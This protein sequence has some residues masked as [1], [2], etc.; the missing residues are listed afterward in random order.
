MDERTLTTL[1]REIAAEDRAAWEQTNS[2]SVAASW[3]P[4][5]VQLFWYLL[6]KLTDGTAALVAS[7]LEQHACPHCRERV[8]LLEVGRAGVVWFR[9]VLKLFDPKIAYAESGESL[10]VQR[11]SP[12]GKLQSKLVEAHRQLVLEVRT[13]ETGRQW[14]L[15]G[16][17]LQSTERD[18]ELTGFLVLRPNENENGWYAAQVA[19]DG[20]KAARHL[21][22]QVR[23][24]IGFVDETQLTGKEQEMLIASVERSRDDARARSAWHSWAEDG[25]ARVPLEAAEVRQLYRVVGARLQE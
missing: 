13:K 6:G 14:R 8:R 18:A 15:V 24:L 23:V 9:Q 10:Y 2:V 21:G 17:A 16:Y 7:H 4:G 12:D 19:W 20:G 25:L 3:H 11:V 5:W 1:L 22:S